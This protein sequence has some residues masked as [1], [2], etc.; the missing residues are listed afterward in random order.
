M[1][2]LAL[3]LHKQ[4]AMTSTTMEKREYVA[5][6]KFITIDNNRIHLR[7]IGN[8]NKIHLKCNFGRLDVIGNSTKVK[9]GDNKGQ[10]YYCGNSGKLY[11]GPNSQ[12]NTVKYNGN[13][14]TLK[15]MKTSN[16]WKSNHDARTAKKI[17]NS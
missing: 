13:D 10:V 7:I 6:S 5:N 12:T 11:F 8:D 17:I 9:I 2:V 3:Q 16:F 14:G 4:R 1:D 15:M